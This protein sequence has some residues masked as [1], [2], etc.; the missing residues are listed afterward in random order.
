MLRAISAKSIT[1]EAF[2]TELLAS[3]VSGSD[4][5][6]IA[7]SLNGEI[8]SWNAAAERMFGYSPEEIIG[9]NIIKLFPKDRINEEKMVIDKISNGERVEH[10]RTQRLNKAGNL[11]EISVTIS[12]I[13]DQHGNI[14][15][16]SKIVRDITKFLEMENDLKM[17]Y[18]KLERLASLDHL[19]QLNNRYYVENQLDLAIQKMTV[20]KQ[21]MCAMIFDLDHFKEV[22]DTFGHNV[23]DDVIVTMSNILKENVREGDIAGRWGGEEF[24]LVCP[25]TSQEVAYQ[26]AEDVRKQVETTVFPENIQQTV[27]I[28]ISCFH[29]ND[30]IK[31][32]IHRA[33]EA[34]YS[35][36]KL[37]RNTVCTMNNASINT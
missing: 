24:L 14:I 1:N 12:P 17:A 25:N 34:L 2:K 3:I 13:Y 37:G 23:G 35:A 28:G 18:S 29:P 4:D 20:R 32:F 6:I 9:Q 16:A 33:D 36:K 22:N 7:K 30:V 11:L 27:S 21:P 10:F 31:T 26:M 8:L 19:T 5:A 15:A